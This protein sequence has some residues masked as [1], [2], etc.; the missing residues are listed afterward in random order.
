MMLVDEYI[1]GFSTRFPGTA[2]DEP[3]LIP[4]SIPERL[5]ELIAQKPEGYHI[6]DGVAIHETATVEAGAVLKGP[7]IIGKNCFVGAHAYLRGGVYLVENTRVG[8]GCE[9]KCS[10]IGRNS[11]IAHFNFVGDSL[12]GNQVNLEAGAIIANHYNERTDKRIFVQV[13]GES[14]YAQREK[15]GAIVG[16]YSR[17][18]ANAVL[19]PGTLLLPHSIVKRLELVEQNPE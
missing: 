15:L 8:P 16:D 19:S 18:G 9:I 1:S 7:V 4:A 14:V 17:I 11:S 2:H 3:W 5:A 13:D 12:I 10:M 6:A